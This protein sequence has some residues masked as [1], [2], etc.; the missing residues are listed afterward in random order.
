MMPSRSLVALSALSSIIWIG[1]GGGS[2]GTTTPQTCQ[3]AAG[4]ASPEYLEQV[5]CLADFQALAS[6]P[7]DVSLPGARSG[8]VVLDIRPSNQDHL[9]FQN[10]QMYQIHYQFAST[11]LGPEHGLPLIEGLSEFNKTEYS[12][13]DRNFILG[14]ISYYEEPKVWALEIAPYD[15]A[16]AAMIVKLYEKVKSKTFYGS[17]LVFHPTSDAVAAVAATLPASVKVMSTDEIYKKID[18]Q[19]LTIA[20][21]VGRLRFIQTANLDTATLSFQ[22]LVVLD[23]APN[24][25]TVVQGII[26]QEFQT[27]LSHVNVLSANRHTPNMGLR[28]AM[29]NPTLRALEG[30]LAELTVGTSSWSIREVTL[31]EANAF[32]AAHAQPPIT[33]PPL[34]L[35]VQT[36]V[37]IEDCTPDPPAGGSLRDAIKNSVL[38]YGGKAAQYSVLAKTPDVPIKKAF[39]IP[40]YFYDQFM[41]TN[42]FYD[43]VEA[44]QKDATFM[45]DAP[46]RVAALAAMRDAMMKA[47]VD[48]AFQ[49]L[50]KAKLAADYAGKT[51]RFRTSTNSED[52]DGFPCAGC[53]ESHTGDPAKWDSVLEAIRKA[54]AST[55][56]FRT[57][58]ER[59]Y[60]G[61]KHTSVGMALLVHNNFPN[62]E[63]NGVAVTNNPFDTSGLDPAF[64]INVQAGGSVEVVHP[65]PGTSSDQLLLRYDQPDQPVTY[66][67]HTNITYP[68]GTDVLTRDQVLK[69]GKALDAI[70]KRFSPAYG[71][72]SGNTGFYA[73]DCEFKFDNDADPS[74]PATLYIKQARP[75]PGRGADVAGTGGI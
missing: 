21:G 71:P 63:A 62:E 15:T 10:S 35:T 19:P 44:L 41:K 7:I 72:L 48:Q 18:Y 30:K 1:C 74:M 58:E 67:G 54:Y 3:L 69:L 27:P 46:T 25:I 14:A 39:A 8:K 17:Q 49:D 40:M 38:A 20:Q 47:P 11:H 73:M 5:G 51:I 16:S 37:N 13:A 56:L 57:F 65:T 26:S 22:D 12:T 55:W 68:P 31:A 42:G 75:Y 61:I 9:Y 34:D 50:L 53:Y 43:Q 60:Y 2:S 23:E 66:I 4:A 70:H 52:L 45:S 28:G 32:W 36:L 6:T 59:T 29:T 64:Y 24:D 33:L